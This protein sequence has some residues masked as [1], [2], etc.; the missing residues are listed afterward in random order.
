MVQKFSP[1]SQI[2]PREQNIECFLQLKLRQTQTAPHSRKA[3]FNFPYCLYAI[4]YKLYNSRSFHLRCESFR[5][6]KKKKRSRNT[7]HSVECVKFRLAS[8]WHAEALIPSYRYF[9]YGWKKCI[10]CV[11]KTAQWKWERTVM[12]SEHNNLH[13]STFIS[14]K[15]LTYLENSRYRPWEKN[16]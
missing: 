4:Q 7:A 11:R 15:S 8:S 9:L 2:I 14:P 1:L 10:F 5:C 3:P 12:V 16:T 13:T 6:C